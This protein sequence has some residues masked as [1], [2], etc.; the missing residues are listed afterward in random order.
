M[1]CKIVTT[2]DINHNIMSWKTQSQTEQIYSQPKLPLTCNVGLT[3]GFC[4]GHMPSF[5]DKTSALFTNSDIRL[6]VKI[7]GHSLAYS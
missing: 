5:R 1:Y 4:I 3:K 2:G 6:G 7:L